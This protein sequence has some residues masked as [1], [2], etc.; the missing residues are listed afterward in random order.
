MIK[1]SHGQHKTF[2]P[3][4]LVGLSVLLAVTLAA[5]YRPSSNVNS[6]PTPDTSIS[7]VAPSHDEYV[8]AVTLVM[9]DFVNGM[10]TAAVAY[11]RLVEIVVPAADQGT[12]LEL[13]IIMSK[14]RD[15]DTEL[16]QSRYDALKQSQS[17][18]P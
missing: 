14:F 4:I 18:L 5:W 8:A 3:F 10:T 15:G 17:W 11:D 12:H 16:A 1:S 6:S 2:F 7:R 9:S 13:V